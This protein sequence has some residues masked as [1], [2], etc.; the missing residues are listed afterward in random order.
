MIDRREFFNFAISTAS[1]GPLASCWTIEDFFRPVASKG[2]IDIHAHIFNGNDVPI[3][4]FAQQ[5]LLRDPHRPP[6]DDFLSGAFLRL[7]A[8]IARMR[9]PTAA[10][11]IA[12]LEST[13]L[14]STPVETVD[15]QDE[16]NLAAGLA[17]Y[18]EDLQTRG[19]G[20]VDPEEGAL[21][22][23]LFQETGFAPEEGALLGPDEIGQELAQ[24]IYERE[25]AGRRQSYRR[26]SPFLQTLRWA[27]LLT[28]KR[29]D[30]LAE[31]VRLYGGED[32]IQVFSPSIVDFKFWFKLQEEV[33]PRPQQ[34][35]VMSLLAKQSE[36]AIVLNFAPF[37]PLRA[38][39]ERDSDPDADTLA[40]V[41]DAVF[42]HGFAGVKLYPPM[43]FKPMNN[44]DNALEGAFR[45]PSGGGAALDD[46]LERLYQWCAET[47]VP[48]KAHANN[49][50]A[51][52]ICTGRYAHPEN[53]IPV[54]EG[55][56]QLRLN[57]AHFGGFYEEIQDS[58]PCADDGSN[59]ERALS[60]MLE[61]FP[62][63][64]FDL[65]Y[66]VEAGGEDS[67]ERDRV[68]TRTRRLLEETPVAL[69]RMMYGSDWSMIGREPGHATYF[70]N[71]QKALSEIGLE[72]GELAAVE[73]GNAR[74]YLGLFP[75]DA[76]HVRLSSFFGPDHLFARVFPE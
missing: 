21:V 44:A 31:L 74:R 34:I 12:E 56:P 6:E 51:A 43:G 50:I 1:L 40:L 73:G 9:T 65:G 18:T 70:A 37:C 33:T 68:L 7:V 27:S 67:P 41:R 26:N 62:N 2:A 35:H 13:G 45:K 64:Y 38:A 4:G 53:W 49:S 46:E 8:T 48:I 72:D 30:I 28:R 20:L 39:L 52:G 69:E 19:A 22:E 66:W 29:A 63:L 60:Q 61:G 57:L 36:D 25:T 71:T 24:R 32:Q 76:N 59:W 17:V 16:R 14:R 58:D 3:V 5:V 42:N 10:E 47:G 54:L 23:Q 15:Q 11:E 75:G 55:N